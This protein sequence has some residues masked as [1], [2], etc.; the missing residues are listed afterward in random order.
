MKQTK[1]KGTCIGL[2]HIS[3]HGGAASVHIQ[4]LCN[5]PDMLHIQLF[6]KHCKELTDNR[7][8]KTLL[9]EHKQW[10]HNIY[11]TT[12]KK[13]LIKIAYNYNNLF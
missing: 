9:A 7:H 12:K 8:V 4:H 13:V 11:R 3:T 1:K 6:Q 2:H 5:E 10:K